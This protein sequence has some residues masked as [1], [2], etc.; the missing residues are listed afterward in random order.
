MAGAG[1]EW[2]AALTVPAAVK[3]RGRKEEEEA[4]LLSKFRKDQGSH[5]KT[6]ISPKLGLK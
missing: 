4:G 3:Q 2:W 5:C 6:K 1:P